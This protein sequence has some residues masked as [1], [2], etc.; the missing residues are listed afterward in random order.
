MGLHP[1]VPSYEVFARHG[2]EDAIHH[3]GTVRAATIDDAE[4]FAYTIFDERK[5]VE[6]FVTPRDAIQTCIRPD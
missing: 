6:M 4:V 1:R 3:V 2:K 5:W